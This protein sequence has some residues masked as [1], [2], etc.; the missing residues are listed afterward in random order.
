MSYRNYNWHLSLI[1]FLNQQVLLSELHIQT[2]NYC[3]AFSEFYAQV[4]DGGI[5]ICQAIPVALRIGEGYSSGEEEKNSEAYGNC[6][7]NYSG[8]I[9]CLISIQPALMARWCKALPSKTKLAT[10]ASIIKQE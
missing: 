1:D 8:V 6:Y 2:D 9:T 7:Y 10:Q 5:W 4:A 3:Q